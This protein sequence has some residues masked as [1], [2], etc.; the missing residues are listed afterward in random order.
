MGHLSRASFPDPASELLG[1]RH[2]K[3]GPL[4]VRVLSQTGTGNVVQT[5]TGTGHL[6]IQHPL[7]EG[8]SVK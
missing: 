5:R 4:H 6:W 3:T 7:P 2:L 8:P 1:R